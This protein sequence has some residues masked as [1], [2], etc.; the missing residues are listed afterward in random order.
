M[1]SEPESFGY[2]DLVRNKREG[3][4]GVR[5]YQARNFLRA[6]AKGD[7]VIFY[8]SN[9][10]PPGVAG[11]AKVVKTAEPDPTQFDP[12]SK[13]YD[14]DSDPSDPRWDWVTVAPVRK[15]K[16]VSIDEL[17][18]IPEMAQSR[19]LARGNRLSVMPVS[20]EEFEAIVRYSKGKR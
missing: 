2:D 1:K 6:M 12:R 7:E 8:H 15:L 4:D 14:P 17:R 19:L 13:Y 18:T 20:D 5:N 10:K 9:S 3:W 11:I 16:F